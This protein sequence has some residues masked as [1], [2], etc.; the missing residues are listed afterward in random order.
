[1]PERISRHVQ[2]SATTAALIRQLLPGQLSG[3]KG[4][5]LCRHS[6]PERWPLDPV[7]REAENTQTTQKRKS[8]L[9]APTGCTSN[10]S[11]RMPTCLSLF[12]ENNLGTQRF[13]PSTPRTEAA[14][15]TYTTWGPAKL[16]WL[17]TGNR[18]SIQ[19]LDQ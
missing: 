13:D 15:N 18:H 9:T 7:S 5:P 2:T 16:W 3:K 1:M 17:S 4:I 14:Q 12:V 10:P 8:H 19:T 6:I 11:K